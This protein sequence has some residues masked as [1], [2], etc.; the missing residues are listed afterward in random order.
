[1]I[2]IL[3]V[4]DNPI[5][6]Y[7]ME[8][9]LS[10][11]YK[12]MVANNGAEALGLAHKVPP[13]LI[14]TDIL[15]PVMDGFTLCK[16]WKRD[17]ELQQIPLIFYTATYTDEKD[18]KFALSLGADLFILKPQDPDV[19]LSLI[20]GVLKKI[21]TNL[22]G[23]NLP[24]EVSEVVSLREYNEVLIRKLEHKVIE[25]EKSR[26]ELVGYARQLE[27]EIEER[28]MAENALKHREQQYRTLV[29]SMNEGMILV[30]N[31][32]TILFVNNQ[33][34]RMSGYSIEELVGSTGY[35]ILFNEENQ[36]IIINENAQRAKGTEGTYE[37]QMLQKNGQETWVRIS[38]SPVFNEEGVAI[39]SLGVFENI[40]ERKLIVAQLLQ[41]QQLFQ[42]LAQVSPVGIFRTRADGYTTYV[43]PKWSELSGM[44]Y[45]SALGDGWLSAVHPDDAQKMNK[46]WVAD[47]KLR[48][49]SGSEYRFLRPDGSIIWVLGN[50]VPEW[51]GNEII[52]YV[53]TITDVTE[54]KK[55]EEELMM[56][57]IRAEASDRLKSAFMNNI[58]HEVRTPLNGILGFG[59]MI[60]DPDLTDEEKQRYFEILNVS[61]DRL[62]KTISDYMDISVIASGN[63]ETR[64]SLFNL[65]EL[66]DQL[67]LEKKRNA[68]DK[69]LNISIIK[70]YNTKN[71]LTVSDPLLLKKVLS[72]LLENAIKFT[73][74]GSIQFGYSIQPEFLQFFVQD[75]GVGITAEKLG[76]IFEIFMQ[77][78][79]LATR[80]F[81][82]SGLGLSIAK[83]I[84]ELL[85]GTIWAESV[86]GSGAT[87]YFTIK[88]N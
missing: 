87:F 43:N 21:E 80:K 70:P 72:N 47:L 53:G 66:L 48:T 40:Q 15:M 57:K 5:N 60:I 4:D 50:A 78:D 84:V 14:I 44:S 76:S 11:E 75:S 17:N 52:G 30:D 49:V 6:L 74:S 86:K 45:D 73:S 2:T 26:E 35:L 41:Q 9:M 82:G 51:N 42:T 55:F 29:E 23:I 34:C 37:I 71:F 46:K 83:G 33:F 56:A 24:Q 18:E 22:P 58:S 19:F 32:D 13:D 8:S 77:E 12:V 62:L 68:F 63:L 54:R 59:E 85:G 61:S 39:G 36:K 79:P 64:L 7:L 69:N 88:Q 16:E 27:R 65:D 1:M 81:E 28:K 3:I 67:L 25:T 31:A 10:E 20:K 38:G